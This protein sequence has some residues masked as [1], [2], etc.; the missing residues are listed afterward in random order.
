MVGGYTTGYQGGNVVYQTGYQQEVPVVYRE[1]T[2]YVQQL[3]YTYTTTTNP[4]YVTGTQYVTG[5]SGVN[6]GYTTGTVNQ[7]YTTG[8]V[9]QGYTTGTYVTGGSGVR[10]SKVRL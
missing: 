1:N 7:G 3:P 4:Q 6:Q 2:E 10:G 8:T 9:N 5:G